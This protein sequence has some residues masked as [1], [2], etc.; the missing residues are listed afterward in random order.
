M[1]D[2]ERKGEGRDKREGKRG[3]RERG[4]RDRLKEEG[5]KAEKVT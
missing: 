4:T 3:G 1:K 5:L 2:E